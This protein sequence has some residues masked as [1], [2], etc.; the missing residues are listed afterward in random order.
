MTP[1]ER[2]TFRAEVRAYLL[3]NP[4]VLIEAM[5]IL[6]IREAEAEV[7]A[8]TRLL[9]QFGDAIYNDGVSWVGGNPDGDITIVEFLDYRCGY[10]RRAYG[11]IQAMLAEDGKIRR[12]VKEFPI[13]GE[14]SDESAK[15][16]LATLQVLGDEAYGRMHDVLMTFE[17]PV[18]DQ[19]L[20]LIARRADIDIDQVLPAME[21][22]AVAEHIASIRLLA[23]RLNVTGTPAFVVGATMVRGYVPKDAMSRIVAEE[24]ERAR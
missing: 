6:R 12:V 24:R 4:E 22:D 19:T 23:Q 21:S 7:Q 2:G 9:S 14:D 13:L 11:E 3:E 20:P 15:L 10:C 1:D 8:D 16:A 17:G 5:D 18:T